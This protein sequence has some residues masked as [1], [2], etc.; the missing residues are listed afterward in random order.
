M[1][2]Y[3]APWQASWARQVLLPWSRQVL[4]DWRWCVRARAWQAAFQAPL[5][6]GVGT[7]SRWQG[8]RDG[9]RA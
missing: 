9:L 1:T 3:V 2:R 7:W 4:E 6:R 5:L 8:L